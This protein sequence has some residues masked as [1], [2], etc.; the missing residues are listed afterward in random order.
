MINIYTFVGL[1]NCYI[2]GHVIDLTHD[3]KGIGKELMSNVCISLQND[4]REILGMHD[5]CRGDE[6]NMDIIQVYIHMYNIV[7]TIL[8]PN[9]TIRI[10]IHK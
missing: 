8:L 10:N 4:T 3:K 7:Q 1:S 2:L 9:T 5:T 6:R